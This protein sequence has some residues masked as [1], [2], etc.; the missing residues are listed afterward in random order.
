MTP[1]DSGSGSETYVTPGWGAGAAAISI[2][3][4]PSLSYA[5]K[6]ARERSGR[7]LADLAEA[8]RVRKDYLLALEQGAWDRLPARPF[9][10]GYVRAYAQA[11]GLDEE[12][13]A[14][15][16]KAESP[17][18]S[19]PLAAPVGSELDDV[20]PSSKPWIA[21]VAVVVLAVVGWNVFQQV[22]NAPKAKSTD[23][24]HASQAADTWQP[25]KQV[26][27][28][29]GVSG[30]APEGQG[31]PAPYVPP[32]L[33]KEL[34]DAQAQVQ[35]ASFTGPVTP[36]GAAFN[37]SGP[38]YGAAPT[39]SAVILKARKPLSVVLRSPDGVTVVFAKQ[40]AT[41]EAYR[42]PLNSGNLVVDVSDPGGVETYCNGEYCG[43]L[44]ATVTPLSQL[45][46]KAAALAAQAAAQAARAAQQNPTQ[47]D[48]AGPTGPD[49]Q[50]GPGI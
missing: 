9:T 25:G 6:T 41:G 21:G 5:L 42:A 50:P 33:E 49:T 48:E 47:T 45:N 32:G 15:R 43:A 17:D 11:L 19:V 18:R 24:A 10:V 29:L 28:N 22:N 12:T 2:A 26:K 13:A 31:L 35:P 7:S 40:L 23:L 39:A 37:P 36:S 38:I 14:D 30:P 44:Q 46:S 20:K 34:G 1:L 4:A 8:T 3:D 16:Y 27:M